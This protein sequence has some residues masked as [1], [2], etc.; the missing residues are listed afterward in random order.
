[1]L[2]TLQHLPPSSVSLSR[3]ATWQVGA[4]LCWYLTPS[5]CYLGARAK[6]TS[7]SWIRDWVTTLC[8]T[9]RPFRSRVII[10]GTLDASNARPQ[11]C[12]WRNWSL[13]ASKSCQQEAELGKEPRVVHAPLRSLSPSHCLPNHWPIICW[14]CHQS[15]GPMCKEIN[16]SSQRDAWRKGIVA[17]VGST[18]R[19]A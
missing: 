8:W 3:A 1:M 11:F 12:K 13:R 15:K 17:E 9:R 2:W 6:K 16:V 19:G 7:P 10:S 4:V 18:L 14:L 5:S